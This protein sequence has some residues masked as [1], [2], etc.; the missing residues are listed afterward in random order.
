MSGCAII[1]QDIFL[2]VFYQRDE[3][4]L[5]K[6]NRSFLAEMGKFFDTEKL[7]FLNENLPLVGLRGLFLLLIVID[8]KLRY[9]A[10]QYETKTVKKPPPAKVALFM[11]TLKD[12]LVPQWMSNETELI[13]KLV[14]LAKEEYIKS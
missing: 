14:N 10:M 13:S 6:V 3:E 11:Q 5:R 7:L 4:A 8:P 9:W 1:Q 2:C 12:V